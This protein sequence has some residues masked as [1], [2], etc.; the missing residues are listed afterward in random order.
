MSIVGEYLRD[1]VLFVPTT[2]KIGKP[3]AA[4]GLGACIAASV[5]C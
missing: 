5:W 1:L 2:P 3:E 4:G